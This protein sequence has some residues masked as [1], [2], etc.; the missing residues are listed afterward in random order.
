MWSSRELFRCQ[1]LTWHFPQIITTTNEQN[2][3]TAQFFT[4][5]C[6]SNTKH[7]PYQ[8]IFSGFCPVFIYALPLLTK[9]WALNCCFPNEKRI[10]AE[11]KAFQV[12]TR[13]TNN[14]VPGLSQV[15]WRQCRCFK[16]SSSAL[17]HFAA[18]NYSKCTFLWW[19]PMWAT[20]NIVKSKSKQPPRCIESRL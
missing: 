9:L 16:C 20:R 1:A 3:A 17:H 14:Q 10:R 2:C 7:E 18:L 4:F 11:E 13:L 12:T 5:Q 19:E 15:A 8:G 6:F